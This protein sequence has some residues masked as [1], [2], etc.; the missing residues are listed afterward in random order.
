MF[1][2]NLFIRDVKEL[3]EQGIPFRH[4]TCNVE[5]G[6]DCINLPRLAFER[7]GPLPEALAREFEAYHNRPDGRRL[8]RIM[9]HWF[10]EISESEGR[11]GDLYILFR[12]RNPCHMVVRIDDNDPP[13][14]AEAYSSLDGAVHRSVVLPFGPDRRIAAVF[15]FP[16]FV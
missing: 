1:D 6:A 5:V 4:N 7:Q 11:A 12:R 16:D 2:L 10:T 3:A 9:R 15:R 14:I 13:M 8:L